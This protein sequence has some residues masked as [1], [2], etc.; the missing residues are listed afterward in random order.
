M[1]VKGVRWGRNG[2]NSLIRVEQWG[3]QGVRGA[4]VDQIH[5]FVL[6]N[7]GVQGS[8][9]PKWIKFFL[10]RSEQWGVKGVRGT[11]MDQIP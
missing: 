5:K 3:V 4:E 1:R 9:G 10:I 2:S 8:E 6:N 11:K 7:G